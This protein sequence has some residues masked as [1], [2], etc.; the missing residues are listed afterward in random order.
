MA[1]LRFFRVFRIC[2]KRR[3]STKNR[4]RWGG[5]RVDIAGGEVC[6]VVASAL[7]HPGPDPGSSAIKSLIANDFLTAQTRRG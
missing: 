2:Q 6:A 3:F 7:R 1:T 4:P 5:E